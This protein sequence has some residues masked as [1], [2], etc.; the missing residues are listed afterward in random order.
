MEDN[1][2]VRIYYYYD[3]TDT[4][5][6]CSKLEQHFRETGHERP[7]EFI[8]WNCY[9]QQPG[10]DGDI[11]IYD[12]IALTALVDKGCLHQLPEV[13][14]TSD[15]FSWTIDKSKVGKKTYGVPL[16]I[17]ANTLI[18]RKKNDRNIKNIFD[19]HERTAIPLKSMLMYY[20]IQAFCNYQ[21]DSVHRTFDHLIELMGAE[22]TWQNHL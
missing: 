7:L 4:D 21:N 14:D 8:S 5:H 11:Y 3:F 10:M 2:S 16:M 13:I 20:Y 19:L 15:M 22:N 9:R 1:T 12:A 18:C 17:C 6:F